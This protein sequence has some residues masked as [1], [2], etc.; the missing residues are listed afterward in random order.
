MLFFAMAA[1]AKC[2]SSGITLYPKQNEISLH[3][4][5][6]IEGHLNSQTT[7]RSFENRNVYLES[8]K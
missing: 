7:I 8:N 6:I 2:G 5:F 3:S 4:Q 1:F